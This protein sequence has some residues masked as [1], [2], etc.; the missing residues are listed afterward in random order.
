[1]AANFNKEFPG[2]S[3]PPGSASTVTPGSSPLANTT[4]SVFIGVGGDLQVTMAG[5]GATVTY[6]NLPTGS[7]LSGFFTHVLA[8]G[9][10]ATD[11]LAEW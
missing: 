2:L 11:I 6:K 4:R 5:N 3:S 9:T 10:T 8:G 1:M 7:R